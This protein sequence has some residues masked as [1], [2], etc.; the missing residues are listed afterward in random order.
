VRESARTGMSY[1]RPHK[2]CLGHLVIGRLQ[3]SHPISTMNPMTSC[4]IDDL[5]EEI[6]IRTC[7]SI[8]RNVLAKFAL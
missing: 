1:G 4:I 3:F 6:R 5:H 8:F 2:S 7:A